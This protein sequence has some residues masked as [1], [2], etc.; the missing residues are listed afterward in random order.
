[1]VN[2]GESA[3]SSGSGASTSVSQ[4]RPVVMP[5]SFAALDSEEWDSWISHFE[6]CA[7]INGWSDER[8]ART[9]STQHVVRI[10]ARTLKQ[11]RLIHRSDF[12]LQLCNQGLS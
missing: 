2:E 3:P 12:K 1:M 10:F 7:V 9:S 4:N 6:D 8:K 11:Q 5:E